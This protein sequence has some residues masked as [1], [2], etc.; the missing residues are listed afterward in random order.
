MEAIDT[1]LKCC[2]SSCI[3]NFTA[4]EKDG[5]GT[6]LIADLSRGD[7]FSGWS[8]H[9]TPTELRRVLGCKDHRGLD[10]AFCFLRGFIDR[11][12]KLLKKCQWQGYII[13]TPTEWVPQPDKKAV[14][15]LMNHR[16]R[17]V[18]THK[19]VS[20]TSAIYVGWKLW[21]CNVYTQ[22]F[23]CWIMWAMTYSD[24]NSKRFVFNAVLRD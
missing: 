1:S 24:L 2:D 5:R 8:K 4:S 17:A 15:W 7:M 16:M 13:C 22:R 6:R 3:A 11:A 18:K 12:T 9:F 20:K 23:I 10:V 21:D 19:G 14:R